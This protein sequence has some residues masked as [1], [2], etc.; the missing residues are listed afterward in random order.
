MP[1]HASGGHIGQATSAQVSYSIGGSATQREQ[2]SRPQLPQF[3]GES[4][5][6]ASMLAGPSPSQ[7]SIGTLSSAQ[8]AQYSRLAV[9]LSIPG[10]VA[11][12]GEVMGSIT[13][14]VLNMSPYPVALAEGGLGGSPVSMSPLPGS[15]LPGRHV[16]ETAKIQKTGSG[17]EVL[18]SGGSNPSSV[19]AG[20]NLGSGLMDSGTATV[21]AQQEQLLTQSA[22]R[23][24]MLHKEPCM[25]GGPVGNTVDSVGGVP[26]ELGESSSVRQP[27][28][29]LTSV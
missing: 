22:A 11:L 18:F 19:G 16:G 25:H 12:P 7:A 13:L 17:R 21:V 8:Q 24:Q 27:G 14:P 29:V 5:P 4:S 15:L 1:G 23:Q 20:S 2:D 28:T 3:I 26:G 10:Q 9:P 6:P